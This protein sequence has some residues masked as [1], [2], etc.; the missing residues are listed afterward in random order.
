[1]RKL[2]FLLIQIVSLLSV[3]ALGAKT[4]TI[5]VETPGQ[6]RQLIFD[7][8]DLPESLEIE[9]QLNSEDLKCIAEGNGLWSTLKY[10]DVSK[11]TFEYGGN[12]YSSKY[13]GK[14]YGFTVY[15]YLSEENDVIGDNIYNNCFGGVFKNLINLETVILPEWLTEIGWYAF[16]SCSKL[17]TVIAGTKVTKICEGAFYRTSLENLKVGHNIR[18]IGN[19]SFSRTHI[20]TIEA[21]NVDSIGYYAFSESY[22]ESIDLSSCNHIGSNAFSDSHLK[23][24]KLANGLTTIQSGCFE[25][26]LYLTE[27]N[28]PA[29]LQSVS[30]TA[31]KRSKW[32]TDNPGENGVIYI[33]NIAYSVVPKNIN[34]TLKIKDGTTVI[35]DEF[36]YLTS[37]SAI[38]ASTF[39]I[40]LPQSINKIGDR[41]F[42]CVTKLKKISWENTNLESIGD[43]A[44][45]GCTNFGFSSLPPSLKTIG[46][47][48]FKGCNN[49]FSVNIGPN[50]ESIGNNAFNGCTGIQT[51]ELHAPELNASKPFYSNRSIK[52]AI[53]GSEVKVVPENFLLGCNVLSD[54]YFEDRAKDQEL[55]LLG[56]SIVGSY[57]IKRDIHNIPKGL[58]YIGERCFIHA[59]VSGIDLSDA[60][61][62][63]V[64]AFYDARGLPSSLILPKPLK[65]IHVGAFANC[66]TETVI[67]ESEE[68]ETVEA[69]FAEYGGGTWVVDIAN[70]YS[71]KNAI[72]GK[73]VKM[74]PGKELIGGYEYGSLF[75]GCVE[76]ESVEFEKRD[77]LCPTNLT[78]GA[79]IVGSH[80]K[81]PNDHI[82]KVEKWELPSGTVTC[83]PYAFDSAIKYLDLPSTFEDFSKPHSNSYD[84]YR[85]NKIDTIKCRAI[86]PP[87]NF[88]EFLTATSDSRT[89]T[90]S[91]KY[92]L[93]LYVPAESVDDYKK[94]ANKYT[95]D[96]CEVLPLNE[97]G[98][99]DAI[100]A[101]PDNTITD[102]YDISGIRLNVTDIAS[103]S[104]GTYIICYS[105]GKCQK[106]HRN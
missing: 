73:N 12:Y 20:K 45:D 70:N 103:L 95:S 8:D 44:F 86:T 17:K 13:I 5:K 34:S 78:I 49:I 67:V 100:L 77:S 102:I 62:I 61:Y 104:S 72:I 47:S 79:L 27:I 90:I 52:K 46:N 22:I 97:L 48:A 38:P 2:T 82:S 81:S 69:P 15:F 80:M 101:D 26:T 30:P 23:S 55:K 96:M 33:N 32:L 92:K 83:S 25:N 85:Y 57:N 88:R 18:F 91:R 39:N 4:T 93:M 89:T 65:Q 19:Y 11:V 76:L 21:N 58:R 54:I 106:I 3:S 31:F 40:E 84:Y 16:D 66:G 59:D 71:V 10:L 29:S 14:E 63:G 41:S 56:N 6:L 50:I 60:E 75:A 74:L 28:F 7:I 64:Y 43:Q 51:V 68:L 9:G 105:S 42:H 87:L 35:N 99:V 98:A 36:M 1:M 24:V 94:I 37:T 53:I